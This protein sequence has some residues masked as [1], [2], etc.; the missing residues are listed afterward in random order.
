MRRAPVIAGRELAGY[1]FSPIAY[2]AMAI[3]LGVSGFL[4]QDDLRP[5][6]PATM[7]TIM[8]SM[9]WLLVFIVPLLSMGLVAQEWSGG[10]ME[11]L[12]TAPISE[13]DVVVGKFLGA[14]A[15]FAI[16]LAPTLF[17][18][19]VLSI[20]AR[21]DYGPI[22]SGYLGMLLVGGLFLSV[23]LFCSTI[24]RSQMVAA[25]ST[26]A[27]LFAIT[28]VPWWLARSVSLPAFWRSATEQ[29]VFKRYSDF[30]KGVIDPAHVVFFAATTL[31]MLFF[32]VKIIEARRWK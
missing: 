32:S 10:T 11:P 17:Y 28:I 5:G 18:L 31:L 30:A 29:M 4:F 8:E 1:F 2:V 25:V 12:L 14:I 13:T 16:L 3:F 19:L 15:F 6:E 7:R 26:I 22:L 21:P 24:T 23:G 9:V 20:F 27:I